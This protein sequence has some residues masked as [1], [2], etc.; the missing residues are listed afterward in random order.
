MIAKF[1]DVENI[2][3]HIV[4]FLGLYRLFYVIHWINNWEKLV[5][6]SFIAGIVQ[7]LLYA[8]FIYYFVKSNQNERI[9][10]LPI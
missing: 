7:T 2:T 9:I 4:F 1:N 10:K 8:D 6:T 3:A 5:I